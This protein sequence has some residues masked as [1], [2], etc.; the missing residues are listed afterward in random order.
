MSLREGLA[1]IVNHYKKELVESKEGSVQVLLTIDCCGDFAVKRD[2]LVQQLGRDLESLARSCQDVMFE[3]GCLA[4]NHTRESD[5]KELAFGSEIQAL[6]KF[7][8]KSIEI[9]HGTSRNP[10]HLSYPFFQGAPCPLSSMLFEVSMFEDWNQDACKIVVVVAKAEED[11]TMDLVHAAS[12]LSS[13]T[14]SS[15]FVVFVNSCDEISAL[16]E[17][18]QLSY[19]GNKTCFSM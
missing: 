3:F 10:I 13:L 11:W 2:E 19:A 1:M 17:H 18:L 9:T 16:F 15:T 12:R 6:D 4:I 7:L 14:K 8:S 5:T